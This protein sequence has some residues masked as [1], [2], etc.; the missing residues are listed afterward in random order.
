MTEQLNKGEQLGDLRS[1]L[2]RSL[3]VTSE[4]TTALRAAIEATVDE[5][6]KPIYQRLDALD[7]PVNGARTIAAHPDETSYTVTMDGV[8]MTAAQYAALK[9]LLHEAM[10][11]AVMEDNLSVSIKGLKEVWHDFYWTVAI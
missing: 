8:K 1:A 9:D 7:R 6:L 5:K 3:S 11:A 10:Q 4:I 2:Q